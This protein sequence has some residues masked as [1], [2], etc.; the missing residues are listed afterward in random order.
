MPKPGEMIDLNRMID[1]QVDR[2][3]RLDVLWIF[4][5]ALCHAAHCR[6]IG[7]QRHAGE[8]LQ[9]HARHDKRNFIGAGAGRRPAGQFADVFFGDF[10]AVAIAQHRLQ[11]QTDRNRQARNVDAKLFF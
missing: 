5:H 1:H 11:Y 8:V 9:H 7:E 10:F 4:A 6:Q 2:N 3:Q